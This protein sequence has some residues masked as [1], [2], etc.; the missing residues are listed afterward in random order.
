MVKIAYLVFA[1]KNPKLLQ[2]ELKA[3]SSDHSAFFVHIDRKSDLN[4]FDFRGLNNVFVL[5]DRIPVYWA[6]I[7]GV[8]AILALIRRALQEPVAYDYMVLLSGSEYPL[9]SKDYIEEFFQKNKGL[10]FMDIVR[11]PNIEAGKPLA[12]I[13]TIRIPSPR[14][15]LRLFVKLLS[16]MGLAQRDYRNYLG[17]LEPYGGHTWWALTNEACQYIT[18]FVGQHSN[19]MNY[20]ENVPQPEESFLHTILG[21]S[22][23]KANIRRNLVYEDWSAAGKRPEM[24]TEMHIAVFQ[25]SKE[26]T[27]NDVFGSGEV[28]FARKFGDENLALLDEIDEIIKAKETA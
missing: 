2:R 19:V 10:E 11:I 21:N 12:H 6:E 23:F 8:Q 27:V 28:L 16:K 22:K 26:V 18:D 24:I 17:S 25:A 14:P 15:L 4:E 5:E 3:L 13:N 1:Y 9:R 20:F 7:S